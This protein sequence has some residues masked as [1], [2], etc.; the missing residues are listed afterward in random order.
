[1]QKRKKET[2]RGKLLGTSILITLISMLVVGCTAVGLNLYST[3]YSLKQTMTEAVE[4]AANGVS[5]ELNGYKML[6]NEIASLDALLKG[7]KEQILEL[8]ESTKQRHGFTSVSI[9]DMNGIDISD[10][11]DLS[12]REYFQKTKS[13]GSSFVSDPLVRKDDGTMNLFI[14]AP[15][16]DGGTFQGIVLLGVDASFLCDMVA[17]IN[18]GNSGNAAILNARGDTIGFKEVE[19]VLEAYNTQTEAKSDK[20][21]KALAEIEYNMTQG[22]TGFQSYYYNG[23]NKMMAYAP[24]Q[25]TNGWSI[26]VAVA[27]KEFMNVSYISAL[28]VVVLTIASITAG[29]LIM[30]RLADGIAKPINSCVDRISRLAQGDLQSEV[31]VVRA[32]DETGT[33]ADATGVIVNGMNT[34][35]GDIK[36]MLG[37]IADGNF[38]VNSRAE[39]GYMGDY[40]EILVS[41][42]GIKESLKEVLMRIKEASGQVSSGSSQMS[43]SAGDLAEGATDQAG[44]VEELQA[45]ITDVA[46]QVSRNAAETV[47]AREAAKDVNQVVEKSAGEMERMTEAM[48]RISETSRKIENIISSIEEIA[49]QTNLLSLNASI[50]AARAGELGRGFAVVAGE[51]GALANQSAKAVVDTRA[52]IESSIREVENGNIIT[53]ETAK[54][55]LE[56]KTGMEGVM[57]SIDMVNE[58]SQQQATAMQQINMGIEQISEVVQ[59]NSATAEETSATSQELT[60][61]AVMLHE[62]VEKFRF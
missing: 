32:R 59:N 42:E 9:V 52:L 11:T 5:K 12:D 25:G 27:R 41:T 21:L 15:I 51:I 43:I 8:C 57:T 4:I 24:I 48:E 61:Q 19:Y 36:Y 20:K 28:I 18:V 40:H 53:E 22:R 31:P 58:A 55:L 29:I 14:T 30:R 2:I 17:E 56:V 35:I 54:S 7:T 13:T 38:A 10:G 60:A 33:L 46:E 34:I 1:M 62:L 37:E 16:M 44:A 3:Y 6:A 39:E 26:D 47:K 49:S 23:L 45:T 50:E